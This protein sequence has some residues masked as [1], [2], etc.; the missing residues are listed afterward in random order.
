MTNVLMGNESFV[1][2][3]CQKNTM[4]NYDCFTTVKLSINFDVSPDTVFI[5]LTEHWE[6]S[7]NAAH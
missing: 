7:G 3:K 6:M 5:I 1:K 2:N 4:E